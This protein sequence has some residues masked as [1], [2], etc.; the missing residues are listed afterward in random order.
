[1]GAE[2]RG[3]A[4]SVLLRTLRPK[5]STCSGGP[6]VLARS[7]VLRRGRRAPAELAL[8]GR[9]HCIQLQRVNAGTCKSAAQVLGIA[10]DYKC[11]MCTHRNQQPCRGF[12]D[13]IT[14]SE[15]GLDES[16]LDRAT[17][18]AAA[19]PPRVL[20][21]RPSPPQARE[22]PLEPQHRLGDAGL[23][24][25]KRNRY[26]EDEY[27][28]WASAPAPK[29]SPGEQKRDPGS[30]TGGRRYAKRVYSVTTSLIVVENGIR[31]NS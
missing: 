8:S 1:M 2:S 26:P 23:I 13:T 28:R 31:Q 3:E 9:P 25:L 4:Q 17:R 21:E 19:S 10:Y 16:A 12:M 5:A 20:H 29:N 14:P 15:I 24:W 18:F 6:V 7:T 30:F 27:H 11:A 22:G